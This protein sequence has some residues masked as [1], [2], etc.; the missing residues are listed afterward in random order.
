MT[1]YNPNVAITMR[2]PVS[3]LD[4]RYLDLKFLTLQPDTNS[5][6]ALR[7]KNH[8]QPSNYTAHNSI[9]MNSKEENGKKVGNHI[10]STI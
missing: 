7:N 1:T 2:K 3:Q 4:L 6:H 9:F 8:Q 5:H 10:N